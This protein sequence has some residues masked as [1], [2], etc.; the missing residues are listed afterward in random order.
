VQIGT[1]GS[2]IT[3]LPDGTVSNLL[4]GPDP[5]FAMQAPVPQSLTTTIGGLTTTITTN[6]TVSLADPNN[7]LSLTALTET[8]RINGRTF[9][10]SYA[11]A[12]KTVTSTTPAGRQS[13]A[14]ID[15]LGHLVQ[16]Q[17]AGLLPTDYTYDTRGRLATVTQG[18]GPD[19]RT[20]LFTY[21]SAG[22]LETMVDPLGRAVSFAYDAAGRITTQTLPDGRLIQYSYDANGNLTSLTPPRRLAHVFA[23]T[24]VDLQQTYTPPSVSGGGTN[25]TLYTYNA[26]RQLTRITRPDGQLVSFDYDPAGPLECVDPAQRPA[27]IQ[28]CGHDRAAHEPHCQRWGHARL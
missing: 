9:T 18:T 8:I 2:R 20:A 12:T 22:F 19:Q 11:A 28:L 25:Q 4:E 5:R 10:S 27:R 1:N 15:T 6:R 13:L 24:P 16:E 17:V 14:T 3:T 7:P 23:Y 26:D 21:T